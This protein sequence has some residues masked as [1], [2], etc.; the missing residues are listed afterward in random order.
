MRGEIWKEGDEREEG[1][2]KGTKKERGGGVHTSRDHANVSPIYLSTLS[3]TTKVE[4]KYLVNLKDRIQ[5][6]I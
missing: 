3:Y 5:Y 4:Y 2:S 6:S 1:E